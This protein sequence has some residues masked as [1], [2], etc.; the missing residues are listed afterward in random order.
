MSIQDKLKIFNF[1][2]KPEEIKIY[3]NQN[4]WTIPNSPTKSVA[5]L[6]QHIISDIVDKQ[7]ENIS[8]EVGSKD[9]KIEYAF[10]DVMIYRYCLIFIVFQ[11]SHNTKQ[12]RILAYGANVTLHSSWGTNLDCV[13]KN[14]ITE[15]IEENIPKKIIKELKVSMSLDAL[16]KIVDKEY[17]LFI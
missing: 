15:F 8:K 1:K 4:G 13:K 14:D 10:F 17:L 5:E 12:V 3:S 11:Y 9:D 7:Y 16:N 6:N 2:I